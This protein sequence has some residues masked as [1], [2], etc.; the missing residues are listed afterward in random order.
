MGMFLVVMAGPTQASAHL[1]D[2]PGRDPGPGATPFPSPTQPC[3]H[4]DSWKLSC[5]RVDGKMRRMVILIFATAVLSDNPQNCTADTYES[6]RDKYESCANDKILTITATIQSNPQNSD[7]DQETII[8]SAVKKLIN[9]CGEVLN[10]CFSVLKV[11]YLK[12]YFLNCRDFY[13]PV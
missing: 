9:D 8:C 1:D 5:I 6:I 3:H 10:S 13:L 12:I 11:K 4:P 2:T 7:Q